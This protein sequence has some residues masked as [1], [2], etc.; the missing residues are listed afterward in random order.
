MAEKEVTI[1]VTTEADA[2]QVED[3]GNVEFSAGELE[4]LVPFLE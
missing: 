3:L 1:K 2:S 4:V